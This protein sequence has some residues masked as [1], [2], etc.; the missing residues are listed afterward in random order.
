MAK[1]KPAADKIAEHL[2]LKARAQ[3]IVAA[4]TTAQLKHFFI[5]R[6]TVTSGTQPQ[7]EKQ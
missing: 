4:M 3:A 1:Y 5:G 2:A 6:K 7:K